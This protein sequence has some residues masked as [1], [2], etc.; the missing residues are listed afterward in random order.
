MYATYGRFGGARR[1]S[2]KT[3]VLKDVKIQLETFWNSANF[4]VVTLLI[5]NICGKHGMR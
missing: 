4:L 1:I 3:S 5:P 2:R